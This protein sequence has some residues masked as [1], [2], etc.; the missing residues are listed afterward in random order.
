M[1]QSHA[2]VDHVLYPGLPGH[3]GHA[4][5]KQ[6]MRDFGGMV[7]FIARA[8]SQCRSMRTPRVLIPR[9]TR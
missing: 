3:A 7:S 2:A 6:Q 4:V 5:A 9:R 1:L 8:F